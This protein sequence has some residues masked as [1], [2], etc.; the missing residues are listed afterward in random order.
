MNGWMNPRPTFQMDR[1]RGQSGRVHGTGFIDCRPPT[2]TMARQAQQ[3]PCRR[4]AHVLATTC[5]PCSML[6]AAPCRCS[7]SQRQRPVIGLRL[8]PAHACLPAILLDSQR[9]HF[10]SSLQPARTRHARPPTNPPHYTQHTLARNRSTT[11]ALFD[12]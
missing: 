9:R 1:G 4:R 11:V 12:T 2:G 6:H 7:S 10:F 5:L 3:R 8:R